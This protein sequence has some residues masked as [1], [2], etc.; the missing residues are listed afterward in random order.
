[1][2]YLD[3]AATTWPK[4]PCVAEA[5]TETL[6]EKGAN[7]GRGGHS[8]SLAAGR[9]IYQT[10]EL[11]AE[12]F[13][14]RD[15][16]HLVFTLNC[17]ESLNMALQ[18]L[19]KPGDHVITSG[20]EHNAVI[21]PLHALAAQGVTYSVL[22]CS[23]DGVLDP[24]EIEQAIRPETRLIVLTHAS[25][26]TGTVMP[27]AEAGEISHRRGLLFLV[28]AAQTAGI[29]PINVDEMHID[30][31]AFPGHKGLYGPT[32]TG[33]LY[34]RDGIKL[35]PLKYG[36]TGSHSQSE[37][38]PQTLPEAMESGTLNTIGIAGLGAGVSFVMQEGVDK[39][40]H[41]EETL[42]QQLRSGLAGI[43]GV[44]LYGRDDRP[45]A[46]TLAVNI[47][48]RDSGEA[49]FLLDS[50]YHIAVRAGLHCSARGHQTLGTTSQGVV[51]FSLSYFNRPEEID[52]TVQAM[53]E[54]GEEL[55]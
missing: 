35:K 51:R 25:N 34:I 41:Y 20:M 14:V 29:F 22:P 17:T 37:E 38:Q 10:R 23:A 45:Q 49:A 39:I 4:P 1:V 13:G 48:E 53:R 42:L 27:V 31:L 28:D 15:S 52:Q 44:R 12:F 50:I 21:R 7:P 16:S 43:P 40:R 33:G 9:M 11:L 24:G 6:R 55:K 47:G 46:P 54:I 36:G 32:G 2:I 8:M 26:I 3:N 19:L 5:I 18:G 30:L